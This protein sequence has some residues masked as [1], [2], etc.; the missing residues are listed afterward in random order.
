M[1]NNPTTPLSLSEVEIGLLTKDQYLDVRNHGRKYHGPESYNFDIATL[2]RS[3]LTDIASHSDRHGEKITLLGIDTEG[4]TG[5][6][7]RDEKGIIGIIKDGTLYHSTRLRPRNLPAQFI[8]L[9]Y[10]GRRGIPLGIQRAEATKYP[11][12]KLHLVEDIAATNKSDHPVV[13]QRINL[14]GKAYTIRSEKKPELNQGT[15]LAVLDSTGQIVGIAQNEWGATL[16]VVA[17]EMR[18]SGLGPILGEV[19]YSYNP[20]FVSGGMTSAG[21]A[22]AIKMWENR[23]RTFLDRGWYSEL[24]KRGELTKQQVKDIV[25]GLEGGRA[26]SQIPSDPTTEAK[27]EKTILLYVDGPIFVLYDADFLNDPDERWIKGF[28]FFRDSRVGSFL[29]RIDY[30]RPWRVQTTLMAL[31]IAKDN[32]W[33]IWIGEG[34]G[35]ML[36]IDGIPN[37]KKSGDYIELTKDAIPVKDMAKLEKRMRKKADPYGEIES[38]LLEAAEAKWSES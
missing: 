12:D 34:Y 31:Q 20:Y 37:I 24:V 18:G 19:W 38:L 1:R 32:G 21:Q 22:N 28:G 9:G 6:V 5:F 7:L 26:K 17:K 8:S 10:T 4:S 14:K 27:K 11:E 2:N 35:D 3:R 29:Y 30:D 16:I 36:E 15:S 33:P 23:V 13:L 25:S